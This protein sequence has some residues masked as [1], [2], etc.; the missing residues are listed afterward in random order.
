MQSNWKNIFRSIGAGTVVSG[1]FVVTLYAFALPYSPGETTNPS[2][3]PTD[4]DCTVTSSV[5]YT[6]ATAA[7]D[8]GAKNITTTGTGSFGS[9]SLTTTSLTVGNGGT[10]NSSLTAY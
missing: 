4:A 7:V 3:L 2:C 1:L 8:L 9:L 6:G 5:P 10:G